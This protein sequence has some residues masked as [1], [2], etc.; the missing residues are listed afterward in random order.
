MTGTFK[1]ATLTLWCSCFP[2][3]SW[4]QW[5]YSQSH[6]KNAIWLDEVLQ[7]KSSYWHTG[8]LYSI[9]KTY[10][11]LAWLKANL[12]RSCQFVSLNN[13]SQASRYRQLLKPT[14]KQLTTK[15]WSAHA[16]LWSLGAQANK[17]CKFLVL[18][19]LY[20]FNLHVFNYF[21]LYYNL[22]QVISNSS[23]RRL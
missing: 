9:Y 17:P 11:W 14:T 13:S 3:F 23:F 4:W 12:T 20:I 19:P 2:Y 10:T 16:S 7:S 6:R 18:Y 21:Q 5:F 8:F 15:K 22:L 1:E